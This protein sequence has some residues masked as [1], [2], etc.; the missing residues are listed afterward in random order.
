MTFFK[1]LSSL[2]KAFLLL[3]II[4]WLPHLLISDCR[5][6]D[7]GDTEHRGPQGRP[8]RD[9]RLA[10]TD[11][12]PGDWTGITEEPGKKLAVST[13][14]IY[15][16]TSLSSLTTMSKSAH[17]LHVARRYVVDTS[18]TLWWSLCKPLK[19]LH[20]PYRKALWRVRWGTQS[21]ATTWR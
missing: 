8:D 15:L 5:S 6:S 12:N 10:Q 21:C 13:Y 20:C 19:T 18:V 9:E 2:K 14:F 3:S 4:K 7:T 16:N 11:T 17:S 1:K